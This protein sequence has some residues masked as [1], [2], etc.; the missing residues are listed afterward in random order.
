[1]VTMK[2]V[3][4][5]AGVSVATV[6]R[7]IN[8]SGYTSKEAQQ[9]IKDSIEKLG[10]FPNEVARSLFKQSSKIIGLLI[11]DIRNPFFNA[12]VK[13][14]EDYASSKGYLIVLADISESSK[15]LD[16]YAKLF[17]QYHISGLL[18]ATGELE[19]FNFEKSLPIVYLDRFM[20]T[21]DD[22]I[23]NDN[24]HGGH[25]IAQHINQTKAD[26]ILVVQ[27]PKRFQ[28]SVDRFNGVID[29][30]SKHLNVKTD[31]IDSYNVD[32]MS[33]ECQ[34]LLDEYQQVDTIICPND[35]MAVELMIECKKRQIDVPEAIQ[36][37][38]YDGIAIG[39]YTSPSLT[40][41]VQPVYTMG[42][43]AA[44]LLIDR[45][46]NKSLKQNKTILKPTLAIR[47]ST[48]R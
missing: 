34:R 41:V 42:K 13:A 11:P 14:V 38:G 29:H 25:L 6:S 5:D 3:A 8:K 30:L 22:S 36:I 43:K 10:Y 47:E 27:G 37:V 35:M 23:N 39:E 1:L 28:G 32:E 17:S 4:K 18:V 31:T 15:K 7:Y 48:R 20:P 45:I 21:S 33:T 24:Y 12:L 9:K 44:Q 40:T 19:D 16:Q 26:R 46:E 2:D